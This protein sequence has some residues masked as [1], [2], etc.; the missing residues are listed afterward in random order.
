MVPMMPCMGLLENQWNNLSF[1]CAVWTTFL[2]HFILRWHLV[3]VFFDRRFLAEISCR[4]LPE[5]ENSH[6]NNSLGFYFWGKTGED[7]DPFPAPGSSLLP[8]QVMPSICQMQENLQNRPGGSPCPLIAAPTLMDLDA[9]K[10]SLD[11]WKRP[12]AIEVDI[13]APLALTGGL[14]ATRWNPSHACLLKLSLP[15]APYRT[16]RQLSSPLPWV[17]PFSGAA[18]F[19]RSP[20]LHGNAQEKILQAAAR[21]G[22]LKLMGW[23]SNMNE[24]HGFW[25]IIR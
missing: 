10:S 3:V 24:F 13:W 18:L 20:G 21:H 2:K 14:L 23:R 11:A 5:G 15:K 22:V 6:G 1:V 16:C 4:E 17:L 7:W 19:K 25:Y 9:W 12:V 8:T